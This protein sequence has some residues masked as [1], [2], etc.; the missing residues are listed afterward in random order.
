M[1]LQIT[2]Y[3]D[4][5]ESGRSKTHA[6]SPL[7]DAPPAPS[8]QRNAFGLVIHSRY[9][10]FIGLMMMVFYCVDAT[11]EYI[12]G[13]IV[14]DVLQKRFNRDAPVDSRSNNSS[15]GSIPDTSRW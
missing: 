5:R 13:S 10:L 2:S 8:A 3:V 4:R 11:G 15:G 14:S 12:L 7:K 9:W 6:R 1:Q